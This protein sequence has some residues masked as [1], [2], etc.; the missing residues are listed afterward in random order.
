M[1]EDMHSKGLKMRQSTIVAGCLSAF[2]LLSGC[3][4]GS[5][6]SAVVTTTS[7][8][9]TTA[10]TYEK[11]YYVD[12][13]VAGVEYECGASKGYTKFDG[14]FLY[15]KAKGC[16]FKIG[17][18][19]IK[20][21]PASTLH[22]EVIIVEENPNIASLLQSLDADSNDETIS[23]HP[24]YASALEDK[25]FASLKPQEIQTQ[26]VVEE[27]K[28]SLEEKGIKI[29]PIVPVEE[30]AA[31]EHVCQNY[32]ELHETSL[33]K[34]AN[35]SKLNALCGVDES[36]LDDNEKP[37]ITLNGPA[38]MEVFQGSLFSDPGATA[39][40]N[41]DDSVVVVSSGEVDTSREGV[42]T[43]TYTA[44][45]RA[46]NSVT[47][48]RKVRV[49]A[50]E[51]VSLVQPSP[52]APQIT[53]IGD[54]PL[55][56]ELGRVFSDPGATASDVEDGEVSVRVSGNVDTN[57]VG[58]YP[59]IYTATDSDGNSATAIRTVSVYAASDT[60]PPVIVLAGNPVVHLKVNDTFN[61]PGATATDDVDG[62]VKVTVKGSVDT[63]VAKTYT[64]TYSAIDSHGNKAEVVR[65]VIVEDV[66]YSYIPQKEQLSDAMA[67]KFLNM[68]TFG[69]TPELV[70]E[71][72]SKGVVA[73]VDDQL[74]M[75]YDPKK[76]SILRKVIYRCINIAPQVYGITPTDTNA[77]IDSSYV[78]EFLIDDNGK[79]FNQNNR[80]GL[81]ELKTHYSFVFD[82]HLRAKDQLRQR[83]AYALS[84]IIIASQ[85]NDSFFTDRGETLSYYY[86]LLLKHAFGNY[87]DLLY[88]ISL[89]PTMAT[90]LT[91]AN[92]E[93][94]HTTADGVTVLPDENYGREIMQLFSIGLYELNMDGTEKRVDGHRIPTYEQ[95]DVNEMSK[96]FTGLTYAHSRWGKILLKGD[97]THPLDCYMQYHDTEEKHLL[98]AVL[99]SGQSCE[100]DVR[101]AVDLLMNH[102]NVAPFIAKKLILRL[103]KSN[104][105]TQYVQRVAE[106][107]AA[108][109]GDLK[110]TIKAV[111]LDQEIWDNI[112]SDRGVK[113]KEPYIILT[114]V[115]RAMNFQPLPWFK[116]THDDRVYIEQNPG[117]LTE[118]L[119]N[120][121]GEFPTQSP[122]VFN[123]Y[124]DAFEPDNYEFKVRGFVAPELEIYTAK[125]AVGLNNLIDTLSY[126]TSIQRRIY[127]NRKKENPYD[128]LPQK[129]PTRYKGWKTRTYMYIDFD[130]AL[131]VARVNGFGPNL[132]ENT[133]DA[134][135]T[136]RVMTALIDY[137]SYKLLGRKLNDE[138]RAM[139]IDRYG[140]MSLRKY[141]DTDLEHI[142]IKNDIT[143]Y[144]IVPMIMD[145]IHTDAFMVH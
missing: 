126:E 63:S 22:K 9:S 95:T 54:S 50:L 86:D 31:L 34:L 130:E 127:Y 33:E 15:E 68:A 105:T 92:N 98:G 133:N 104:P 123:F 5:S 108:T 119:Y 52:Q 19:V 110:E 40:D 23:I 73:W 32:K 141:N 71:L 138:Q 134:A 85:S 58:S 69:A 118:S 102:P 142:I 12:A 17:E 29:D 47:K 3:N 74:A 11:G 137:L 81:S 48:T 143:V 132:I 136:K 10:T 91:F 51:N 90:F 76:E 37:F 55:L 79:N 16:T 7:S 129:D 78:D 93:K 88:D 70:Q 36:F 107:F 101:S 100:E 111:L 20:E 49:V 96:V 1:V 75:Q 28:R 59:L 109:G 57:R 41:V 82:Q 64:L 140:N 106:V 112:K 145:I 115:L 8:S 139:M 25:R 38:D 83:V 66:P 44:T 113:V 97:S 13:P 125:Y 62:N 39:T 2:M 122:T 27:I 94:E 84:Q 14:G 131:D 26:Q 128:Y 77:T 18:L 120:Y 121:L 30:S 67:V 6:D 60:T 87:G 116:Y 42:Y 80:N 24:V 21:V 56:V 114:E 53:L 135:T 46:G 43:I 65:S 144:R 117:F 35:R 99:P 61:D 72:K 89:S 45:D 103:T 4:S 124:D